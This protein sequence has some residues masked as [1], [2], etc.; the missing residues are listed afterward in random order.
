MMVNRVAYFLLPF[1][2][3]PLVA[4]AEEPLEESAAKLLT[5]PPVSST[6]LL[7]TVLGLIL[8]L[9]II[10][11][12][13]WLIK[14]TN[15]FQTSVNGEMKVIAGLALG[16]RERAVLLQVGEQQILVGVTTQ[17]VQ[18][19]HVLE[20]PIP[21]DSNKFKP[22]NFADKLHQIIKQREQS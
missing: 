14:R 12:L 18:T 10:F 11:V 3:A 13:A 22:I 1:F 20:T 16:P 5:T 21:V 7:E 2:V 4:V 19:L 15:R 6:A 8:V 9:G 17:H